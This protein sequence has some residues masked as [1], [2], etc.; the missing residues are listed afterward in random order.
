MPDTEATDTEKENEVKIKI[1]DGNHEVTFRLNNG[2]AAKSLYEQLPLTVEVENYGHNEKIFYPPKKLDTSDVIEG[3]GP[4]GTLAYF[5]PWG[6]IVIYYSPFGA[7][8]GLYL[9][10]EADEGAENIENLIG[11]IT[12]TAW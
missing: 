11:T 8:S 10:G 5:S 2:S 6:D 4:A 9:L 12:I 3:D 7:Y 1:T